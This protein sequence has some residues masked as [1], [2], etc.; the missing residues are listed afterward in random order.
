MHH[1]IPNQFYIA[2]L[3]G[4]MMKCVG[5]SLFKC[6][7]MSSEGQK[8]NTSQNAAMLCGWGSEAGVANYTCG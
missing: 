5:R 2:A 3:P 8:M 4:E 7:L 1:S 6:N